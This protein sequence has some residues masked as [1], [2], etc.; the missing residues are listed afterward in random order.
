MPENAAGVPINAGFVQPQQPQQPTAQSDP[1][2]QAP[3]APTGTV[4]NYNMQEIGTNYHAL[5]ES[6]GV[7]LES[8]NTFLA[9]LNQKMATMTP[10]EKLELFSKLA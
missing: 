4:F 9:Q 3:S 7:P 1:A 2:A 8:R 6:M 5:C 10:A